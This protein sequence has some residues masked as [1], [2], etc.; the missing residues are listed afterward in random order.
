MPPYRANA[1]AYI[2]PPNLE[3]REPLPAR[4]PPEDAE[5]IVTK[6]RVYRLVRNNPP[7]LDDFLSQLAERPN[8]KLYN[9]S[10]CVARGLSVLADRRDWENLRRLP[11]FR[12]RHLCSVELQNGA[13]RIQKT[14]RIPS[15]H[16][17]W[18][19]TEYDILANCVVEG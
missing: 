13:G 1:I 10:E 6:R 7:T 12:R 11:N 16:T 4:C 19:Y 18:P 2:M 14:G 17:W 5:E 15:H 8:M 3:Y 9:T